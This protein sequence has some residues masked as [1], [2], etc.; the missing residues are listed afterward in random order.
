MKRAAF[1]V[2]L[3]ADNFT[4]GKLLLAFPGP[5]YSSPAQGQSITPANI[6]EV[7]IYS[8]DMFKHGDTYWGGGL[9]VSV[10]WVKAP[11]DTVA[12]GQKAVAFK[13]NVLTK[14]KVTLPGPGRNSAPAPIV[15]THSILPQ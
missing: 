9:D 1:G 6:S 4:T 3:V 8:G 5:S 2:Q 14:L 11:G 15:E 12:L 7:F 13:R 10:K